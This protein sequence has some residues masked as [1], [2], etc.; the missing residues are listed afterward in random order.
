ML[1]AL[2]ALGAFAIVLTP[3]V[4][5]NYAVSGTPFGTAGYAVVEGTGLFPQ[6]QLERSMHPDLT[7]VLWL[8]PYV[9][10]A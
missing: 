8:P 2:A 6:F 5:R 10:K 7:H 4:I 1:H 9:S 3:W